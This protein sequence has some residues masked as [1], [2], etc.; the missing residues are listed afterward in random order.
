[1]ALALLGGA[2][3]ISGWLWLSRDGSREIEV[4]GHT[5]RVLQD[6]PDR[7]REVAAYLA[8]LRASL[9]GFVTA[10][11][12]PDTAD[13]E[14]SLCRVADKWSGALRETDRG[15]FTVDKSQVSLCVRHPRT[16]QLQS[17]D[18]C[19]F[20]ALHELAHI[21]TER[22]GHTPEFWQNFGRLV[23]V[24]K[25]DRLLDPEGIGSCYCGVPVGGVP[26][27]TTPVLVQP[28]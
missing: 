20:V 1:M 22:V 17:W 2:L 6:T 19:V 13:R 8:Q 7:M 12:V 28:M 11:C 26:V 24:A 21:A 16:G 25:A 10:H 14:A 3:G 27:D 15:A 18:T 23:A 4:G 5:F 9:Q